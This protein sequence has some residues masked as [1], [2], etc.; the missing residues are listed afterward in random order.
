MSRRAK[1]PLSLAFAACLLVSCG[2][3][4]V[5][6]FSWT[7]AAGKGLIL[8]ELTSGPR[9]RTSPEGQ[10]HEGRLGPAAKNRTFGLPAEH[11]VAEGQA[12]EFAFRAGPLASPSAPPRMDIS[13]SAKADGSSPFMVQ[14]FSLHGASD[15]FMLAL[16]SASSIRCIAISLREDA[17]KATAT[18]A[19]QATDDGAFLAELTGIRERPLALGIQRLEGGLWISSGVSVFLRAGETHVR[20]ESSVLQRL[21]EGPSGAATAGASAVPEGILVEYGGGGAGR[22]LSIEAAQAAGFEARLRPAGL[23]SVFPLS[24]LKGAAGRVEL[25][26]PRGVDFRAFTLGAVSPADAELA[27]F[28]R[29]LRSPPADPAA[30]YDLYRWDLLPSVLIFDFRNY[31][32]QDSYLKRLAFFVEKLGFKGRLAA[33]AEIAGLHGW[34]AHDYRPEDLAAFFEKAR[35]EGFALSK[36][37]LALRDLLLDRGVI[38][39]KAEAFAPGQGAIISITR[40]SEAYLRT[41]FL[42]HESTHALYFADPDYRAFVQRAWASMDKDEKWF[43]KLYFGWMN[44]NV[45]DEY[46][47]ANEYQAYLLQQTLPQVEDYFTKTLPARLAEKHADLVPKLETY[48][49][50][51]GKRFLE[52]A[53][54]L[55]AWLGA[56]YGFRAGKA[57][58]Y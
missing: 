57:A 31:E 40:E 2:A 7:D 33:D 1:G 3:P 32:V 13:L 51:Y 4:E 45:A 9:R 37:E 17:G 35:V 16:P 36:A 23:R 26:L 34:N 38:L 56:K 8:R 11:V 41:M 20:V 15:R 44:Y 19:A 48:M 25:V 27:D 10:G 39:R 42:T 52:R 22:T 14:S 43:W 29:I 28:G 50:T 54:E 6:G 21:V 49:A 58:S 12:L 46:L 24:V 53:S 5:K 55:D 18:A 30:D 47:M